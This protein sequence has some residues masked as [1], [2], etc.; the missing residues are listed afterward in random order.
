MLRI[1]KEIEM[2]IS[3]KLSFIEYKIMEGELK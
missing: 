1:G 3:F 2:K